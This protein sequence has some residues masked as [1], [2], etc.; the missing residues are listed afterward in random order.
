MNP[1]ILSPAMGKYLGRLD[2]LDLVK[3]PV[4][5]KENS[6]LK[7]VKLCLKFDLVSHPARVEALVNTCNEND[8]LTPLH[9]ITLDKLMCH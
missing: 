7:P 3:Q 8:S 9:K 5:E 6:E 4:S 1:V 2:S